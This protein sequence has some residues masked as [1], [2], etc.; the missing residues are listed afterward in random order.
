[1]KCPKCNEH[2]ESQEG[3]LL[4]MTATISICLNCH[5]SRCRLHKDADVTEIFN[6]VA[7]EMKNEQADH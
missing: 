5:Y 2:L 7:E 3:V 1:M 6:K 4:G